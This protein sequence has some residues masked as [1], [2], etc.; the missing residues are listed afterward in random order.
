MQ[1]EQCKCHMV[2]KSYKQDYIHIYSFIPQAAQPAQT[3]TSKHGT[4]SS[5]PWWQSY[6]F[7]R[8]CKAFAGYGQQQQCWQHKQSAA[9]NAKKG[10]RGLIC[11]GDLVDEGLI[12][13]PDGGPVLAVPCG[14]CAVVGG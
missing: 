1:A 3:S 14:S 9:M 7:N 5:M 13:R 12:F 11:G 2:I 10:T 4:D 6:L 8:I